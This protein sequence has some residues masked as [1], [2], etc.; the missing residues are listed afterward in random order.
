MEIMME[1]FQLKQILENGVATV[2][3]TKLDGTERQM[4][5]TLLSEYL[6]VSDKQILTEGKAHKESDHSLSVWDIEKSAWR[7]F[8][9]DSIKEVRT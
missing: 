9:L 7:A 6:P 2:V 4:K 3:F 8:R 5:C 1:K